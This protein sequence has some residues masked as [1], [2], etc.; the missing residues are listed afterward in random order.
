[1]TDDNSGAGIPY[2]FGAHEFVC[3]LDGV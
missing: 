2:P 1:M 3:L